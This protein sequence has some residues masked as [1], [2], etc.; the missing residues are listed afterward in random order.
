MLTAASKGLDS[1][2]SQA[3]SPPYTA[4]AGCSLQSAPIT[5]AG[6]RDTIVMQKGAPPSISNCR[7]PISCHGSRGP[8]KGPRPAILLLLM[9]GATEQL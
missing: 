7:V 2:N 3:E 5:L 1:G 4:G 9:Q 8:N 6:T